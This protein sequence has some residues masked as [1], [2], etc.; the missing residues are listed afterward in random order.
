MGDNVTLQ[1]DTYLYFVT[2]ILSVCKLGFFFETSLALCRQRKRRQAINYPLFGVNDLKLLSLFASTVS[3]LS[4]F[5][6][7]SFTLVSDSLLL[8]TIVVGEQQHLL[9]FKTSKDN[10]ESTLGKAQY[11]QKDILFP[12]IILIEKAQHI[13]CIFH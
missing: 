5:S 6:L 9:V 8:L 3:Q 10:L 12:I 1:Q 2:C 4:D 7:A 11:E 13:L